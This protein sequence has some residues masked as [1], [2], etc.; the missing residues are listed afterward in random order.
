M[1]HIDSFRHQLVG[2][3]GYLP[4]YHPL[5]EIDGDFR[6]SPRQLVLGEEAVN[7]QLW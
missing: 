1:S 2:Y 4:V 5:E 3:L 6:C 7:I